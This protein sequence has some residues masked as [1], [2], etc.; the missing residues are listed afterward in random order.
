MKKPSKN[1]TKHSQNVVFSTLLSANMACLSGAKFD[2][3]EGMYS[4]NNLYYNYYILFEASNR[5][6]LKKEYTYTW[7]P[8]DIQPKRVPLRYSKPQ[9]G[10][11]SLAEGSRSSLPLKSTS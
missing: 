6:P 1:L 2:F 3:L 10:S 5:D 11:K 7:N 4:I 8:D 9:G